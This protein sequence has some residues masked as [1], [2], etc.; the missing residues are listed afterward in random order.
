MIFRQIA[1]RPAYFAFQERPSWM[2]KESMTMSITESWNTGSKSAKRRNSPFRRTG[3]P[4]VPSCHPYRI[5]RPHTMSDS[6]STGDG[7]TRHCAPSRLLLCTLIAQT[8]ESRQL[9][10]LARIPRSD[11]INKPPPKGILEHLAIAKSHASFKDGVCRC[12][13]WRDPPMKRQ[14]VAS[15]SPNPTMIPARSAIQR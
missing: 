4:G 7:H 15:R 1:N 10:A 14:L 8:T 5:D 2:S 9:P 11:W 13:C 6:V 3:S 12:Y